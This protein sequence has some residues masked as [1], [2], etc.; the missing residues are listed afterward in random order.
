MEGVSSCFSFTRS[1]NYMLPI[2]IIGRTQEGLSGGLGPHSNFWIVVK[3]M[4]ICMINSKIIW[5]C[6]RKAPTHVFGPHWNF[7][8]GPPLIILY[9]IA[10]RPP[11]TV[12]SSAAQGFGG[13]ITSQLTEIFYRLKIFYRFWGFYE[14][15]EI[16]KTHLTVHFSFLGENHWAEK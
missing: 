1:K 12:V 4:Y 10:D 16:L 2:S 7:L 8:L 15:V 6:Q 3:S 11:R 9:I 14:L 5:I 13:F